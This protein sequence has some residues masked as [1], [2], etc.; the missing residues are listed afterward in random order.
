MNQVTLIERY[1]NGVQKFVQLNES[2][3]VTRLPNFIHERYNSNQSDDGLFVFVF[4]DERNHFIHTLLSD[5]TIQDEINK[6]LTERITTLFCEPK[7]NPLEMENRVYETFVTVKNSNSHLIWEELKSLLSDYGLNNPYFPLFLV[8]RSRPILVEGKLSEVELFDATVYLFDKY[9]QVD[10]EYNNIEDFYVD[11]IR[12]FKEIK[13]SLDEVPE[14]RPTMKEIQI[15]ESIRKVMLISSK[16][17]LRALVK[18]II[19]GVS[20]SNEVGKSDK[21]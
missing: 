2:E 20:D 5:E 9:K 3:F 16:F 11:F 6:L 19:L 18:S 15:T 4:N 17:I 14:T 8:F 1:N 12:V 13:S 10:S 21:T 7:V